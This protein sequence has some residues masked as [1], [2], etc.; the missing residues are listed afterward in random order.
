MG[1]A[2]YGSPTQQVAAMHQISRKQLSFK[3]YDCF[4]SHRFGGNVGGI[5]YDAGAL[6]DAEMQALTRE[7]NASVTGFVT[8]LGHEEL[9]VRFFMPSGEIAMCGHVTLGLYADLH[10]MKRHDPDAPMPMVMTT[11]SG[12]VE[13]ATIP[14]DDLSVMLKFAAPVIGPCEL[15]RGRDRVARA[16]G[17]DTAGIRQDLPLEIGATG[18]SHLFVPIRDLKTMYNMAPDFDALSD[19]SNDL[20]VSTVLPFSMETDDPGHTL[21]CRDF[22]PAVGVNEVPASGTTNS[23]LAGYLVKNGL[24]EATAGSG[25]RTVLAEQGREIG[26]PSIIRSE[27]VLQDGHIEAVHVGGSATLAVSGTVYM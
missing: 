7:L 10:A 5:V 8:K 23:A 26:R 14:G 4:T 12:R 16:L 13:V 19:L 11:R 22:C 3:I 18:L 9:A 25:T 2:V 1:P 15:D 6:A 17:I 21:H 27:I 20:S 24:V